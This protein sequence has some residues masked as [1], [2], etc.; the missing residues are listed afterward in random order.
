MRF[1]QCSISADLI[2]QSNILDPVYIDVDEQTNA[3]PCHTFQHPDDD[4][5]FTHSFIANELDKYGMTLEGCAKC[6]PVTKHFIDPR[7]LVDHVAEQRI[8][9]MRFPESILRNPAPHLSIP[10]WDP[11]NINVQLPE[12]RPRGYIQVTHLAKDV[13]DNSEFIKIGKSATLSI[14]KSLSSRPLAVKEMQYKLNTDIDSNVLI[15]LR[16]FLKQKYVKN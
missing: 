5:V 9:W 13:T 8:I 3:K 15:S 6:S 2:N 7:A 11:I 4:I 1:V 10:I 14:L 16:D 12:S